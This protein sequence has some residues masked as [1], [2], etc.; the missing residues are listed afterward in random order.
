MN[1]KTVFG[2]LFFTWLFSGCGDD[3]SEQVAI[4]RPTN[5]PG[6]FLEMKKTELD[7]LRAECSRLSA[8]D[9]RESNMKK[10]ESQILTASLEYVACC[11]DFRM[12]SD[13][14]AN[15]TVYTLGFVWLSGDCNGYNIA[16]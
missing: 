2:L 4:Q 7:Q 10:F 3:K 6:N 9:N 15:Q 11:D 14:C 5:V 13:G 16:H 12:T 1:T 8:D